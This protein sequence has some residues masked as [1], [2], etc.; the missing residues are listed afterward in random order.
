MELLIDSPLELSANSKVGYRCP[1]L[2]IKKLIYQRCKR[3]SMLVQ[4]PVF[5]IGD[6]MKLRVGIIHLFPNGYAV[7][8]R[9]YR[10]VAAL[11]WFGKH[12]FKS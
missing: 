11:A 5:C 6:Y 4:K 7:F 8:S 12:T 2:S 10:N 3:I 9:Q 1:L